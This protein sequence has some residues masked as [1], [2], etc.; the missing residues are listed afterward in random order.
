M[1]F[2]SAPSES[3]FDEFLQFPYPRGFLLGR[4]SAQ[5]EGAGA[6]PA[7]GRSGEAQAEK[8]Q[9]AALLAPLQAL[10]EQRTGVTDLGAAAAEPISNLDLLFTHQELH[11]D[12]WVTPSSAPGAE[13]V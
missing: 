13:Q 3:L 11:K 10:R 9:H 4:G 2:P 1:E 5:R 8:I 6:V 7:G 12:L